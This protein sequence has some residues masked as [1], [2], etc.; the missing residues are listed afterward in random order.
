MPWRVFQGPIHD[1]EYKCI[2]Q[3]GGAETQVK[4]YTCLEE[5]SNWL[6]LVVKRINP[7]ID[8]HTI[9]WPQRATGFHL[10]LQSRL[11]GPIPNADRNELH[12][13][14]LYR[15]AEQILWKQ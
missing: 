12:I 10:R 5:C 3:S 13:K 7:H 6:G 11:R 15:A 1:T 8:C 4:C 9:A 14:V 2:I